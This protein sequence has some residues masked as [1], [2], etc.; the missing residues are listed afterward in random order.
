MVEH[1]FDL[2]ARDAGKPAQEII[3]TSPIFQVLEEGLHRHTGAAKDPRTTHSPRY[4]LD[5][6]AGR[7]IQHGI[8]ANEKYEKGQA[9]ID[10][11]RKTLRSL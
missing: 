10:Q 3:K 2:L 7:P 1:G 9:S 4:T 5:R 8:E 6:R 11:Y